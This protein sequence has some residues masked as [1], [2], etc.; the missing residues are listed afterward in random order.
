M[1]YPVRRK[2]LS[3]KVAGENIA[4]LRK[5]YRIDVDYPGNPAITKST[6]RMALTI[7]H[8][9]HIAGHFFTYPIKEKEN[10]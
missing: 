9:K 1:R 2:L 3:G 8:G 4:Y 10:E 7:D 6:V 5:T